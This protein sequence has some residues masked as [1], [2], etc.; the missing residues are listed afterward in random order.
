MGRTHR[1]RLFSSRSNLLRL[2]S[3]SVARFR[4]LG[5]RCDAKSSSRR[6]N[7]GTAAL[8]CHQWFLPLRKSNDSKLFP[9]SFFFFFFFSALAISQSCQIEEGM[10]PRIIKSTRKYQKEVQWHCAL[11]VIFF[12][13]FSEIHYLRGLRRR[14]SFKTTPQ[15][16]RPSCWCCAAHPHLTSPFGSPCQVHPVPRVII[17]SPFYTIQRNM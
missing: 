11:P 6:K 1:S 3:I 10:H 17:R 7:L 2:L 12:F 4:S 9:S 16:S 15:K 14:C 5:V 13:S 8:A